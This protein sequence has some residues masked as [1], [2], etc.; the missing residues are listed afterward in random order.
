M[1]HKRLTG[2]RYVVFIGTITGYLGIYCYFTMIDPMLNPEPYK[3]FR[4]RVEIENQ[5]KAN[6][7]KYL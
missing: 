3:Q 4:E 7:N 6:K 1:M 2:W 5:N